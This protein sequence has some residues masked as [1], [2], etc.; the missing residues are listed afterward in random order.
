MSHCTLA[1]MGK[2]TVQNIL[3]RQIAIAQTA[4]NRCI[5]ATGLSKQT[6][7]RTLIE[8]IQR[9][10]SSSRQDD[11]R[12]LRATEQM[13]TGQR[14]AAWYELQSLA[15]HSCSPETLAQHIS[16]Q[17]CIRSRLKQYGVSCCQ[18]GGDA[19]ARNRNRKVPRTNYNNGP[20]PRA[21]NR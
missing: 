15:R 11:T 8:N 10:L 18:S 12:H 9:G 7:I 6:Q 4:N 3:D 17:R 14:S 5:L 13:P 20:A 21:L 1:C 16:G 19:S 2:R